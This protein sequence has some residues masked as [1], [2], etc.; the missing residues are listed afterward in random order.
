MKAL[1]FVLL[2]AVAFAQ[3]AVRYND[4][5]PKRARPSLVESIDELVTK[6]AK[7]ERRTEPHPDARLEDAAS[8]IARLAPERGPPPN[9]LVQGALWVHG[10]VEPPP[11]LILATMG[12]GGEAE[13]LHELA[14]DLPAVLSQGR[15]SRVGV[16]LATVGR[17]TRVLVAL[18]ESFVELDP[19]ARAQPLGG[20]V[21]LRGRLRESFQRPEAFVTTPDGKVLTRSQLGGDPTHFGGTFRCGPDKGRYQV[22]VTGEDR[23]GATVVAN[24]PIWCGVQ[25]AMTA[26]AAAPAGGSDE[27][28]ATPAAAEQAV[29]KLLNADRARARL[30]ALQW[31]DK[32]AS[33]ARGHSSDMQLHGFFGHVSPTTGSA[34]DRTRKAGV[35]AMLILENVARAFSPGEAERGL[36][37]SPGHRANILN[38]DASRV[39]VGV[40]FDP[41]AKELLVTQLFS[42]PPEKWDVHT[43]DDLRRGIAELRRTRKLKPLERDVVLDDLAQST[44]REIARNGM[45]AQQGGKRIEY[46]LQS[47]EGRWS[48]VRSLFAVV[49]GAS[50]VVDSLKDSLADGT[51]THVGLGVEPGRR[52]DGGSGLFVVIVLATRR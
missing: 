52:K 35:D 5:P 11:H 49:A 17:E 30:P 48:A 47:Q 32:L 27:V 19:I 25:P 44:A 36:M 13:L 46:G 34:A 51:V 28:S 7:R 8:E 6:V 10:I 12:S 22:E 43:A 23:F 3:P 39:G 38:H 21:L 31:D 2:P 15:Y 18:Q 45:S 41:H 9:E 37:N 33:I 26:Q 14:D 1:L 50:Q 4:A 29:F 16:G 20:L 42:K 24:F 40:V